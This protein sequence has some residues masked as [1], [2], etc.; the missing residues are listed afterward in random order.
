MYFFPKSIYLWLCHVTIKALLVFY[1]FF[2]TLEEFQSGNSSNESSSLQ[3]DKNKLVDELVSLVNNNE[4][5]I[6]SLKGEKVRSLESKEMA[7]SL[8]NELVSLVNANEKEI[9]SL[10]VEKDQV[11]AKANSLEVDVNKL[12][13]KVDNLAVA[14]DASESYKEH[15]KSL[16][17][18]LNES[19]SVADQLRLDLHEERE[20]H[21]AV[22]AKFARKER[23]LA[24]K[25]SESTSVRGE[26]QSKM[27]EMREALQQIKD[28]ERRRNERTKQIEAEL[29][30]TRNALSVA[31]SKVAKSEAVVASLHC[32]IDALK[33]EK[34]SLRDLTPKRLR[35]GF[36]GTDDVQ[37]HVNG[38]ISTPREMQLDNNINAMGAEDNSDT[39]LSDHI[40]K[41]PLMAILKRTPDSS[42]RQLSFATST[43]P[44][45]S[46]GKSIPTSGMPPTTTPPSG[47]ENEYLQLPSNCSLCCRPHRPNVAIKGCQCGRGEC[48]K[49]AHA[50]CIINRKS[51]NVSTCVSHPGTPAPPLP[52]VLCEGI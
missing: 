14:L 9:Q 38:A 49:W 46:P 13:E 17:S 32:I 10:K 41:L 31:N 36:E 35:V 1:S 50:M 24:K 40:S 5:E 15:V 18:S 47:K 30:E 28:S 21:E 52:M 42:S 44:M 20:K 19:Q 16:F 6:Q 8:A 2:Q 39:A 26:M 37:L 45:S 33:R 23:E 29:Q 51:G 11:V 48:M 27:V 7:E 25:E 3:S 12:Q 43:K 4:K 22:V 34:D